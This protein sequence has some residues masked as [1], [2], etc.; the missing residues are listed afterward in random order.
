MKKPNISSTVAQIKTYIKAKKLNHPAIKLSMN[1]ADLVKGLKKAGHWDDIM[2]P[3][4]APPKPVRRKK[5]TPVAQ[6]APLVRQT[7]AVGRPRSRVSRVRDDVY[8]G[9]VVGTAQRPKPP[10]SGTPNPRGRRLPPL[11]GAGLA[12]GPLAAGRRMAPT[13]ASAA[14]ARADRARPYTR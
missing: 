9:S 14:L 10:T 6:Q 8:F 12:A 13:S 5:A 2:K 11:T 1:K 3:K 7:T 4:S